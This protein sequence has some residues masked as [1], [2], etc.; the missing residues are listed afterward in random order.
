LLPERA[1][2]RSTRGSFVG[3]PWSGATDDHLA[4]RPQEMNNIAT[5]FDRL[6][7]LLA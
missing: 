2:R 5:V 6:R 7:M 1:R 3:A 4:N